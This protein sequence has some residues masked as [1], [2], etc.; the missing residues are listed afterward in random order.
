[1]AAPTCRES[2]SVSITT[3][4]EF[5]LVGQWLS[6]MRMGNASKKRMGGWADAE[7]LEHGGLLIMDEVCR[8]TTTPTQ[9][10]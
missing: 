7:S 4:A 9:S 2:L 10:T 5:P 6:Q 8:L 3:L 1:M